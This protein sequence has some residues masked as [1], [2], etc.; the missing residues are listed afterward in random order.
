MTDFVQPRISC[1]VPVWNG[2]RFLGQ[3][4]AS[5]FQ[6]TLPP[7]EVFVVDDGSTDN[8]A[9]IAQ[10]FGQRVTLIQQ[11]NRGPG[12]ARNVGVSASTGD[13]IAFLD[14]DDLW[15]PTKLARQVDHL[16]RAPAMDCCLT[17]MDLLY[18]EEL[19]SP[20]DDRPP[21]SARIGRHASS[22]LMH[23]TAFE[24]VGPMNEELALRTEFEWFGRF[25]KM[26]ITSTVVEE[27]LTRRRLHRNNISRLRSADV[28]DASFAI[29]ARRHGWGEAP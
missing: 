9:R 7:T 2:E 27:V 4:L 12:A 6:Q 23:R 5:V 15:L 14:A 22:L 16:G 18:D 25:D 17:W 1:I 26:G 11:A 19:G 29:L 24:R 20:R 28:I 21:V 10:D 8:S 13:W 3:A